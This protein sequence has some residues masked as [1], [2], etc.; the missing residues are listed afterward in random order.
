MK[1]LQLL[2][3]QLIACQQCSPT[4]KA[5]LELI[6]EK[7]AQLAKPSAKHEI[8]D[9]F[10]EREKLGS[11]AL[12]HGI[13]IPHIRMSIFEQPKLSII[14]LNQAVDFGAE[15]QRPVDLI[16]ALIAPEN[17]IND[18]LNLLAECSA[19]LIKPHMR[20]QL[21]LANEPLAII[22]AINQADYHAQ[23]TT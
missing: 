8:F 10:I 12:G 7:F 17:G 3:K 6:S 18:H 19:L 2:D 1:L 15:D 20:Q 14:Q 13:A 21:R 11:T 23:T 9:A 22:N 4:K 16:F 5:V